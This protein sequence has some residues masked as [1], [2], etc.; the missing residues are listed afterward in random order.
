[1]P[2]SI[3]CSLH[4]QNG[5]TESMTIIYIGTTVSTTWLGN[6]LWVGLQRTAVSHWLQLARY[7]SVRE[8]IW[9][10]CSITLIVEIRNHSFHLLLSNCGSGSN[11]LHTKQRPDP[12]QTLDVFKSMCAPLLYNIIFK[13]DLN[14][15]DCKPLWGRVRYHPGW[16]FWCEVTAVNRGGLTWNNGSVV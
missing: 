11:R 8:P 6:G 13:H 5:F 7:N 2:P 16:H 9:Q 14:S 1:M 12:R 3:C 10:R 15:V 4:P